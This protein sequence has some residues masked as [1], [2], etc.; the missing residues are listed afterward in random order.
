METI[1]MKS[2]IF[3]IAHSIFTQEDIEKDFV[4]ILNNVEY[5]SDEKL[6][7]I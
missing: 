2:W 1:Q 3:T 4:E 7:I 5:L 6:S